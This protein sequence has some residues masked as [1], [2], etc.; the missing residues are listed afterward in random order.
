MEPLGEP[1]GVL[2]V[3]DFAHHPTAVRSTVAA[4]RERYPTRRLWAVFEPRTNTSRRRIFQQAYAGSFEGADQVVVAAV[5][6]AEAVPAEE[7]FD[8]E[9]LARDLSALGISA[10]HIP[11]VEDIVETIAAEAQEEDVVLIM[12]NGAFGGIYGKLLRALER[13]ERR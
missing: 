10:R 9:R 5:H 2:V 12:S 1:G 3:E 13:R 4:L 8:P 7:R 11:E 6:R